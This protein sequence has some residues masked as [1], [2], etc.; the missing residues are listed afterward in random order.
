MIHS[1][2]QLTGYLCG[3]GRFGGIF[4]SSPTVLMENNNES[5]VQSQRKSI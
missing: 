4:I 5:I 1:V 3:G 2:N